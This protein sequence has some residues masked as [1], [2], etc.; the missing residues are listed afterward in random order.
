[1]RIRGIERW[2]ADR[3]S[4]MVEFT[5]IG[6]MFIIVLLGV[7]EMGRMVLVYTTIANAARAGARYAIVHGG[8]RTGPGATGVDAASG[9]GSPCTCSQIQTV[10]QNFASAGLV[11]T[12][13]LT[14]TVSYPDTTNIAGSRVSV[15][16]SYPYDPLVKYF[17]S[18]L[19]D[20]LSSTSEGVITF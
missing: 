19:G 8:D 18:L 7:V 15:T 12:S 14:I 16:V 3:G 6:F 10:V 9:P 5:L 17:N 11:N 4:A 2:R 13:L 1:M 20:T